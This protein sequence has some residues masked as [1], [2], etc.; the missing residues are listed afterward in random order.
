MLEE[1][2]RRWKEKKRRRM[3]AR[4]GVERKE[5]REGDKLRSL[6]PQTKNAGYVPAVW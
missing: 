2:G 3:I 1:K 6:S 4:E 5:E